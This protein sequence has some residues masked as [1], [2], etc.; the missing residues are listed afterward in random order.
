M[1]KEAED[2]PINRFIRKK[3]WFIPSLHERYI[4]MR[5]KSEDKSGKEDPQGAGK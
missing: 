2:G 4:E 3:G 5:R 1:E